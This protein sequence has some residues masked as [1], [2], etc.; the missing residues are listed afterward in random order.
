MCPIP[1]P[2]TRPFSPCRL[3]AGA[4]RGQWSQQQRVVGAGGAVVERA[5]GSRGR[6]DTS[7]VGRGR[8]E[9]A[10]HCHPQRE[11]EADTQTPEHTL[12]E[13]W[14]LHGAGTP[15]PTPPARPALTAV[16]HAGTNMPSTK[17]PSRGPPMT[18]MTVKEP[19]R[20]TLRCLEGSP[21]TSRV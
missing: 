9:A 11:R 10:T 8:V 14:G 21:S 12:G 18:P 17:A 7:N 20:G 3:C 5:V 16:L 15:S 1:I 6:Q 19:C 4:L 13:Q 2:A